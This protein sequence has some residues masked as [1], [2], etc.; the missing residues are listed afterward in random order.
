MVNIKRGYELVDKV[1]GKLTVIE[2]DYSRDTTKNKSRFWLCKCKCGKITSV[3][4]S[5]LVSGKTKSCGCI[6][7]S[8]GYRHGKR[9]TKEY[10]SWQCMKDR[11]YNHNN[12]SYKS[13][14]GRGISVCEEWSNDFMAFYND[15][16]NAP[17]KEYSIDRINVNGNYCKENCRWSTLTQQSN[18]KRNNRLI[19]YNG[20]IKTVA[21]WARFLNIDVGVIYARIRRGD[22][23]PSLFRPVKVCKKHD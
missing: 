8:T 6:G 21:E 14:G 7:K 1:F 12:P 18:N 3:S 20:C 4:S 10:K 16:G 17:G 5:S 11:C 23:P 15:M 13:Y 22:T 19:Q 9:N 2:R